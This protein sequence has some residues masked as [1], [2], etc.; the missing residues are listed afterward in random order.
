MKRT[1]ASLLIVAVFCASCA[2]TTPNPVPVAQV[3][4]QQ[5]TCDSIALEMQQ[6]LTAKT[7]AESD[8]NAQVGKNVALGVAGLFLIVPWFFMDTGNA[9]TVEEKAAQARYLRLQQMQLERNCP[10]VPGLPTVAVD[11][12]GKATVTA[13]GATPV[14]AQDRQTAAQRLEQLNV[15]LQK[16]LISQPEY[17]AKR[18]EILKS[19]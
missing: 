18:A 6:M 12:E 14:P 7:Q 3:G 4:D 13:V 11:A 19:M 8:R 15:L 1:V 9:A 5:K 16:G 17:D 10:A 2:T